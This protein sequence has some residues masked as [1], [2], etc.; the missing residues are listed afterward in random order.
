MRS[1]ELVNI[2]YNKHKAMVKN[3]FS[4]AEYSAPVCKTINASVQKM[5]CSSP[6]FTT[7]NTID[8]VNEEDLG[9]L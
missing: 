9:L 3:N 4:A 7:G 8:S 2:K 6:T 1:V 5:L